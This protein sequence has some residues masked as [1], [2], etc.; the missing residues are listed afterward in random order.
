LTP[1]PPHFKLFFLLLNRAKKHFDSNLPFRQAALK[2]CLPLASLSLLFLLS[3]KTICLGLAHWASENEKSLARQEN[4][5]AL[6]DWMALFSEPCLEIE[7]ASF[8]CTI[9]VYATL[10]NREYCR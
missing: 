8:H 10:N 5:L 9:K 4:L 6:D 3:C 7:I 1:L 2:V